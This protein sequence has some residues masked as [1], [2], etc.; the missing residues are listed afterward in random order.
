MIAS[1]RRTRDVNLRGMRACLLA[2]TTILRRHFFFCAVSYLGVFVVKSLQEGLEQFIG[3]VDSFRVLADN[4]DHRRPSFRFVERVQVLTQISNYTLV[5]A[6]KHRHQDDL[7]L[8][9]KNSI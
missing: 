2:N 1:K 3:V 4:P 6:Q 9:L 8:A 7:E 5:S